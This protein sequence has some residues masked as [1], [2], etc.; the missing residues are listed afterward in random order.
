[1]TGDRAPTVSDVLALATSA[2][3]GVAHLHTTGGVD[4]LRVA[5]GDGYAT[6]RLAARLA[7]YPSGDLMWRYDG[8]TSLL[9]AVWRDHTA[10]ATMHDTTEGGNR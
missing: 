10:T 4:V 8:E 7:A 6:D 3:R 2:G 9:V 1:M 5:L